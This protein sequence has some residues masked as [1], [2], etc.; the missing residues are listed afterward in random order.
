[1]HKFGSKCFAYVYEKKKLDDR[2]EEGIFV[3]YDPSSPA[4]FVFMPHKNN[5]VK[6]RMVKFVNAHSDDPI[7]EE[8]I[9]FLSK[10]LDLQLKMSNPPPMKKTNGT[11][12]EIDY[13]QNTLTIM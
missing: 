13:L 1:M 5:V 10:I 6:A 9:I 3:G 11:L 7:Q 8:E 4:Y 2:A 12:R